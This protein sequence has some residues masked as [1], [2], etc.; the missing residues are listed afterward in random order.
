MLNADDPVLSALRETEARYRTRADDLRRESERQHQELAQARFQ[1]QQASAHAEQQRRRADVLE[2]ALKDIHRA[3]F[4]ANIY[5]LIL[6]ACLKL[7][8]AT[9]GLYVAVDAH[10]APHRVRAVV[11]V[12]G[13]PQSPASPFLESLCARAAREV[14]TLVYNKD[15]DAG[16]LPHPACASE[17]F[18]NFIAAP[19]ILMRGL[20]GIIIAADKE[21]GDF[22]DDDVQTLLHIGDQAGVAVENIHLRQK[23]QNAYLATVSVLADAMQ[24]KDPYT[25]GHCEMVSRYA[26]RI[27]QRLSLDA[28]QLSIV[29]YAALLHDIGKIGVSDG[30]L[31]KPG[32]LLP[33]E[34]DVVR[35]HVQIG[36]DL[37]NHIPAL[38]VVADAVL[39]HHEW[40]DGT[41]YPDC[42]QGEQIPVAS[43]IVG[44]VDSYGAMITRRS[45]KEAFGE[46]Y[47]RAELSRCAGSQFDP[48][49][50]DVFLQVLADPPPE[51][52]EE[53]EENELS[54][55]P[56]FLTYDGLSPS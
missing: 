31:N 49:I 19:V 13:Y 16:D 5:E 33:A 34:R 9:R 6:R 43:R 24:A 51:P 53:D 44:V 32:P 54:P 47:A 55:L 29:S 41:G 18:R 56:G 25:Q 30:I 3:F 1:V 23:L 40:Y 14:E 4:D 46:D 15:G 8:G 52:T 27:G 39:H 20:S 35:S 48:Q 45:Y 42:L 26:R 22:E 11:D 36:H 10:G 12:Q 37:L 17:G 21:T 28:Q 38:S 2:T 50:V 7:T